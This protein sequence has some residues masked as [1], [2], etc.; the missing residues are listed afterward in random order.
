MTG[1]VGVPLAAKAALRP[2]KGPLSASASRR[3]PGVAPS[4]LSWPR[5]RLRVILLATKAG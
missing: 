1:P 4:R 3:D 2:C 5:R